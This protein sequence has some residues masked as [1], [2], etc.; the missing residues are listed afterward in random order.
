M[1]VDKSTS[2]IDLLPGYTDTKLKLAS[3]VEVLLTLVRERKDDDRIHTIQRLLA[4]LAEDAFRLVV[5]GKYNRGKSSLMNAM[6]GQNWLPTGILPLT[7]V[8]TTVRYGTKQRVSI[9]TEGSSLPHEISIKDLPQYVSEEHNPGNQ[10]N[11]D[12]V[13][14]YLP[15]DLLRYG[16]LFIDTPGLGS[17]ISANTEATRKFLPEIDAAIV[18]LSFESPLDQTDL[19]LLARL[20]RL[21]RKVFAIV[22][23]ADL[24]SLEERDRVISFLNRNLAEHL[25]ECPPLFPLSARDG[26]RARV[27]NDHAAFIGS[28]V[29]NFENELVHFLTTQKA[30]IF[31]Q[32]VV[33]RTHNLLEQEEFEYVLSEQ[34]SLDRDKAD[35]LQ[36]IEEQKGRLL[37]KL[38]EAFGQ[39]QQRFPGRFY[40]LFED[41]L[42]SWCAEQKKVVPV[43]P[44][45]QFPARSKDLNESILARVVPATEQLRA[46][47][48]HE[49]D[50]L[51]R[52]FLDLQRQGDELLG[53]RRSIL[54]ADEL[55]IFVRLAPR[56]IE[57]A[58]LPPFT[59]SVPEWIQ[60]LPS[61]WL[62]KK[63]TLGLKG[64]LAIAVDAHRDRIRTLLEEAC[65]R[66]LEQAQREAKQKLEA[67]TRRFETLSERSNTS[68]SLSI[69]RGLSDQ[70]SKVVQSFQA[71]PG[72]RGLGYSDIKI[73]SPFELC[74]VCRTISN[75]TYRFFSRFQY[76]L[77]KDRQLQGEIEKSGGLCPFHTWMYES[78]G[79]PQGIAQ[80]YATVL[81]S[82][83]DRLEEVLQNETSARLSEGITDLL[84]M[85][86]RCKACQVA[87]TA[88][89][90]ALEEISP[91]APPDS[92]RQNLCLIH[93][94]S[95]TARLKGS[96]ITRPYV[97]RQAAQ[98]RR[99]AQDMRQF[100]LKHNALRHYLST[101]GE[102]DAYVHG[103][104]QVVGARQLSYIREVKDIL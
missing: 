76:D 57:I 49:L 84:P 77:T 2:T 13:E 94:V 103:L 46:S 81:E 30:E 90:L 89:S 70:L 31:L 82:L 34:L 5:V 41:D 4:D 38:D 51:A 1:Q 44:D 101:E 67:Y 6:L 20:R 52:I 58:Q 96:D 88:E 65:K 28:G 47:A 48:T 25:G 79:S 21:G 61:R 43:E 53:R 72:A 95:L 42:N 55:D 100:A 27:Q 92:A 60:T 37:T 86:A 63:A 80:G 3:V 35:D 73:E 45:N 33:E 50:D 11:I 78:V 14:I 17:G 12:L 26:L 9:R 98:F 32:R 23:K 68:E 56:D 19:D 83:A 24:V 40:N 36:I 22:N 54:P 18:V 64:E 16:F 91:T 66:W 8:V 93:L 7:S 102:R 15:S 62:R 99:L 10:K 71:A 97:E 87:S 29:E 39:L 85:R 69:L 75:A 59:W 104:M 74:F